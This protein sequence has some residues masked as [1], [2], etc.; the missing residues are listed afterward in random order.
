MIFVKIPIKIDTIGVYIDDTVFLIQSKYYC[1]AM[2]PDVGGGWKDIRL[3]VNY[4]Y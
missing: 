3:T 4:E 2:K 1:C